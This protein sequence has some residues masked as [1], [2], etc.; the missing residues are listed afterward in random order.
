MHSTYQMRKNNRWLK[1]NTDDIVVHIDLFF[2][3]VLGDG[4]GEEGGYIF[5]GQTQG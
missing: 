1:Q 3:F 4:M 2:L 5:L